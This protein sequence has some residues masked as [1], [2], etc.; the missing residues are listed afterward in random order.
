L[1]SVE[2]R[3]IYNTPG[4][5]LVYFCGFFFESSTLV[6]LVKMVLVIDDS[7]PVRIAVANILRA[8]GYPVI[9]A[10][11]GAEALAVVTSEEITLAISDLYLDEDT[12]GIGI[13][14]QAVQLR[15]ALK[16]VLMSGSMFP[17]QKPEGPFPVLMKPFAPQALI[18]LAARLLAE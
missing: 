4:L 10:A 16:G 2:I 3:V 13:L 8:A 1:T 5:L 15:P 12:S 11:T 17:G 9:E 14:E 6:N 18:D 7:E